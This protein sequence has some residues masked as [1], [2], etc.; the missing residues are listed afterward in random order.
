[1]KEAPVTDCPAC[2]GRVRRVFS[3]NTVIYKG[4]GFYCTDHPHHK[5]TAC[6]A[7]AGGGC[8]ACNQS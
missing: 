2:S 7:E 3:L 6:P 8:S 5:A 1:M 4:S